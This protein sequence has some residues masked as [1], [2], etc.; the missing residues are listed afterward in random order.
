MLQRLFTNYHNYA[1][2]FDKSKINILS[3]H[4]F[5][6]HKLKFVE[7]INKNTFSKNR[8][9]SLSN[10][11]FEQIKKYLNEHLRKKFIIFNYVLFAF[12]V[13]FIKKSNKKLRYY[14]D[15]KK[16]NVIIKINRY[17]ILLIDKVLIKI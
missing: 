3:S 9:Y 5:Y 10:H 8:I 2:I 16:L 11:K 6:N 1:N 7:N 13:L 12:P 17:F 14:V 4:H 15:Y